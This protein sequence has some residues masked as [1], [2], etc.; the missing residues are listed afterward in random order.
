M[1]LVCC[2][3]G[4][5]RIEEFFESGRAAETR[6]P[7]EPSGGEREQSEDQKRHRHR[8][9]TLVDVMLGLVT[10]SRFAEEREI[11]EAEH[12]ERG[13]QRGGIADKPQDAIGIALLGPSLPKNF[14]LG[15]EACERRDAGNRQSGEQHGAVGDGNA[16]GKIAHVAHVL[17]AA[18][19][20]DHRACAEEE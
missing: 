11:D 3:S 4:K 6:R 15:K 18:H 17:L 5:N 13:H 19:G 9:R 2:F 7:T 20:V 1:G 12:V 16:M 8:V 14:V 10:H